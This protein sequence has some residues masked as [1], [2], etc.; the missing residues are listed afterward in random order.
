MGDSKHPTRSY[1][2]RLRRQ[3]AEAERLATQTRVLTAAT[4]VFT[5]K[6]YK[7]ATIAEIAGEANAAVASVYKAAGSKARL[8][9]L[10]LDRAAGVDASS[11]SKALRGATAAERDPGAQVRRLAGLIAAA[12]EQAAP[13]L[14]AH[15][16][17]VAHDP[18]LAA[19]ADAA[20]ARRY[21][22]MAEVVEVL[23]A[24][25]LRQPA[26]E[27]TATLWVVSSPD[28]F[29]LLRTFR[30]W[31]PAHYRD[32][33]ERTLVDQLLAPATKGRAVRSASRGT[34]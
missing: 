20:D 17:G 6:G 4:R 16:E 10:V 26:E 31:T 14:A 25:A 3:R 5:T 32:W 8:L 24:P 33:L 7:A 22:A 2:A 34:G 15:R 18:E 11:S 13:L 9:R 29:V 28:V 12:W 23:P 1:D 21:E 19:D 30:G 27:C